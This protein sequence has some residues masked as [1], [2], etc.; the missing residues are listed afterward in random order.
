MSDEKKYT[1]EYIT[2]TTSNGTFETEK[3]DYFIQ[4]GFL[5]VFREEEF[6][7]QKYDSHWARW[8]DITHYPFEKHYPM[9]VIVELKCVKR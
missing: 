8:K 4:D 9:S 5:T 3:C 2:V 7:E 6:V 1:Y